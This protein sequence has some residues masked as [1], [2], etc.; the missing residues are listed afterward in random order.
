MELPA[1]HAE[2][3]NRT[4]ESARHHM[5]EEEDLMQR[6]TRTVLVV[7]TVMLVSAVV[8][9]AAVTPYTQTFEGLN[10][11]DPTAL[12]NDGWLVYGN[13][14]APDGTTYIGGYGPF[15]AP[16]GGPGFCAIANGQGGPAQGDQQLV[17]YS[18]YDDPNHGNGSNNIVEANVY[19][20]QTIE[21]GDVGATVAFSFDAKRG[22]LAGISEAY[23]FIKTIDPNSGFATTNFVTVNMTPIPTTWGTYSIELFIDAGLV[24]Q[25]LQFGF[26]ARASNYEPSGV[27]YD[28]VNQPVPVEL[29]NISVE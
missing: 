24:D 20:E 28:N 21:A 12:G 26:A 27:F 10:Q 15:P 1:R 6:T 4:S 22:D 11:A 14:W 3:G 7:M 2:F 19:Q 13:V 18:N 17:V 16:N 23:A 9:W 25:L 5:R 8:I 29:M